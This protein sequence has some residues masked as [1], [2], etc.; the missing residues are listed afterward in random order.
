ME[1][2]KGPSDWYCVTHESNGAEQTNCTQ[3]PAHDISPTSQISV[4]ST[5]KRKDS[6]YYS[7]GNYREGL[8]LENPSREPE[9]SKVDNC[10]D[11]HNEQNKLKKG[12]DSLVDLPN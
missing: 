3:Y 9:T 1:L 5:S 7:N 6:S 8:E 10:D 4:C 11:N 2:E 12:I